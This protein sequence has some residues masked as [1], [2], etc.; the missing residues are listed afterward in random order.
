MSA[1]KSGRPRKYKPGGD[2]PPKKTPGE[3]RIRDKIGDVIY[4]GET[5]DLRRRTNEHLRTGKLP[6]DGSLEYKEADRRTTSR[7]RREHERK[8]IQY[9]NPKLNKSRGGEGRPSVKFKWT[10]KYK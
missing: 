8:K 5:N 1:Y 10:I 6:L 3:Y 4:I 2:K 7:T 9:H